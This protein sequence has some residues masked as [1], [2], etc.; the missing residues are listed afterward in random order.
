MSDEKVKATRKPANRN[1]GP[2]AAYVLVNLPDGVVASDIEVVE[3]TR[4]A[5]EALTA[6]VTGSAS[7]YVRIMVK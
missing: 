6:I 7:A 2:R 5:E 1:P 3:V 4:K